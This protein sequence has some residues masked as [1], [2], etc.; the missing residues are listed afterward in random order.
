MKDFSKEPIR[1]AHVILWRKG[2]YQH[3]SNNWDYE[4]TMLD[5]RE[6]LKYDGY[7][8]Q[9]MSDKD[10]M[11][12]IFRAYDEYFKWAYINDVPGFYDP[13]MGVITGTYHNCYRENSVG[14]NIMLEI[15][16]KFAWTETKYLKLPTPHYDKNTYKIGCYKPGMTYTWMN[17][18]TKEIFENGK[19]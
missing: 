15:L 14:F 18:H 11:E 5:I 4:S 1:I 8:P 16:A 9:F 7:E 2:W 6:M 13:L 10:V 12:I 3:T 17:K 19:N